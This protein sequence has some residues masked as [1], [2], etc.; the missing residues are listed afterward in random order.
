MKASCASQVVSVSAIQNGLTATFLPPMVTLPA[1]TE[2]M[3]I[4][5]TE[6][7]RVC[8]NGL[9]APDFAGCCAARAMRPASVAGTIQMTAPARSICRMRLMSAGLR[10]SD[11]KMTLFTRKRTLS[12]SIGLSTPLICLCCAIFVAFLSNISRAA[13]GALTRY[14]YKEYHMGVDVR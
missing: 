7:G 12:V 11:D 6:P 8:T 5:T 14:E 2:I 4:F 1:G 9:R 10:R 13:D 3:L